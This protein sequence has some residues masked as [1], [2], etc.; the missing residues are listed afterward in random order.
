MLKNYESNSRKRKKSLN[1]DIRVFI[2][3]NTMN[4][5]MDLKYEEIKNTVNLKGFRPGKVPKVI[6][7]KTIWTSNF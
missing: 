2:D 1:K 4:T 7:K 3:R 6:L 5:H